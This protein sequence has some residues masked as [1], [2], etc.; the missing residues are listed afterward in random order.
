LKRWLLPGPVRTAIQ[1]SCEE[2]MLII[3]VVALALFSGIYIGSRF[4]ASRDVQ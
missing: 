3:I 4:F 2:P 1:R